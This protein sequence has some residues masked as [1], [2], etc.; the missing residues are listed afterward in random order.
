MAQW[1]EGEVVEYTRWT[2]ILFSLKIDVEINDFVAGQFT[3]LALEIDG[4][5]VA[6]PYSFISA[7][8]VH[9][10]EFFFYTATNGS[11]SNALVKLKVGDSVW[12]KQQP[13]GFFVL[14]EVPA[15][16]D[17]WMFATGTGI[18]PFMSILETDQAWQKFKRLILVQAVRH[19]S[20]LLYQDQVRAIKAR[21]G[22]QFHHQPFVSRESVP[23]ALS[24]R[25]P[26]AIES[27]E[28]EN[29]LGIKLKLEHSQMMLCGNPDMIKDASNAL[30]ERGFT[31]NRR[32]TPGQITTEN[33][34]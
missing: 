26:A 12:V 31:K 2:D 11:L 14:N 5:R 25:I 7:P 4:E 22:E 30:K 16:D 6:R 33:Y 24:G 20:D 13:N 18:A 29:R 23:G 1:N 28:L 21:H 10:K 3:S 34:W 8:Q 32:R 17:L 27:G 15:A 9:P 19:K